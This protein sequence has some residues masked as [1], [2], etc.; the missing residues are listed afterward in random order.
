MKSTRFA[1][2]PSI[3]AFIWLA[4]GLSASHPSFAADDTSAGIKSLIDGFTASFNNHDAHGLS[5]W[6]TEDA[7]FISV[8]QANSHSRKGIE[9]HFVP[10]F[11]GRLKSANRTYTIKSIRSISP[12]VASV[13]MDY[14]LTGTTGANGVEVPPRKGLYDWIVVRQNGKWLISVL[15]ESELAPAPAVVPIR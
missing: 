11:S 3:L 13:T 8:Q 10:L 2:L 5:M 1:A 7:D 14:V 9:D 4:I 15:H 6:F 12:D